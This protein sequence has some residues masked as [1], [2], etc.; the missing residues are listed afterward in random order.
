MWDPTSATI[1]DLFK[2]NIMIIEKMVRVGCLYSINTK[3]TL[4]FINGMHKTVL[5]LTSN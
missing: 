2:G 4:Q 5:Y 1:D 3:G